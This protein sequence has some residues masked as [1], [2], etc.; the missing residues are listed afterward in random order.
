VGTDEPRRRWL[1]LA[2]VLINDRPATDPAHWIG[3]TLSALPGCLLT[4][5][6]STAGDWHIGTADHTVT[7]TTT[8]GAR[9]ASAVHGWLAAGHT[10]ADL[11]ARF[12]IQPGAHETTAGPIIT[13]HRQ[14]R[15]G[16]P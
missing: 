8:A 10:L 12:T 2:D 9:C 3:E 13:R 1:E 4:A 16:D 14:K 6:R 5:T 11:P 15:S 7:L